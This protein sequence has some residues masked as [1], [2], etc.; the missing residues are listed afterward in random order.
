MTI[1]AFLNCEKYPPSLAFL[2]MTLGPVLVAFAWLDRP[3]GAAGRALSVYGRVPMFFYVAHIPLVHALAVAVA[4]AQAGGLSGPL[5]H[6]AAFESPSFIVPPPPG[7]GF[8]LPGVYAIWIAVVVSLGPLCA[9]Y[10]DLKARSRARW[11]SYL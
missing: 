2:L 3:P 6:W 5:V 11:M 1:A 7:F 4:A 8:A 9:W 10:G